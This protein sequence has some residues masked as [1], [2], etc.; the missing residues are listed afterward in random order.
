MWLEAPVE[1]TK[2]EGISIGSRRN[3]MKERGNPKGFNQPGA[4]QLVHASV[5]AGWKSLGHGEASLMHTSLI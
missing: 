4:Q 3:R 1:E 5:R 2:R